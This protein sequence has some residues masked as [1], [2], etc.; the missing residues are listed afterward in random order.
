M[1]M[2]RMCDGMGGNTPCPHP[3]DC[4]VSCGFNNAGLDPVETRKI[5]PYPS[6]PDDIEELSIE[7]YSIG[8]MLIGAIFA[9]LIVAAALLIF[10][11]MYI[12]RMLI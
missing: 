11:G 9:A 7:W 12:G 6:V 1:T 3:Q 5:K 4:T 2:K 8:Q 10:T